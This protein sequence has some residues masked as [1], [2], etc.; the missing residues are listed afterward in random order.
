MI[1]TQILEHKWLYLVT[2]FYKW[3]HLYMAKVQR[4]WEKSILHPIS[5]STKM[6]HF[7]T[8][9]NNTTMTKF[10]DLFAKP[11]VANRR[12]YRCK[13]SLGS[14]ADL[15]VSTSYIQF[16]FP[17][18]RENFDMSSL[19]QASL[20]LVKILHANRSYQKIKVGKTRR[21]VKSVPWA[22]WI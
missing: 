17:F 7:H 10:L 8:P 16:F 6:P 14:S 11:S 4:Y 9:L 15:V 1:T 18:S 20:Q 21:L 2:L 3:V 13:K 5:P 22:F 12:Q 19:I